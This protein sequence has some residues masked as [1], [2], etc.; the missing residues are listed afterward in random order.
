MNWT[1]LLR[2]LLS[3]PESGL[4]V[5]NEA[6]EDV[7]ECTFLR[8]KATSCFV[9]SHPEPL[10]GARASWEEGRSS[11]GLEELLWVGKVYENIVLL[12]RIVLCCATLLKSEREDIKKQLYI[13]HFEDGYI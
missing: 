1:L 7:C 3:C 11:W 8:Q 5:K 12:P 9:Y 13:D 2:E 10:N 6:C 4:S